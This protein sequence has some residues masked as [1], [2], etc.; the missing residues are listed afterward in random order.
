MINNHIG[1]CSCQEKVNC[2]SCLRAP[3][4]HRGG[5]KGI[6]RAAG[7]WDSPAPDT[8]TPFLLPPA[9]VACAHG[10]SASLVRDLLTHTAPL[11]AFSLP[12]NAATRAAVQC[13]LS[14]VRVALAEPFPEPAWHMQVHLQRGHYPAAWHLLVHCSLG[15]HPSV[16]HMK[17]QHQLV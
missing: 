10:L 9:F 16:H 13:A 2:T 17:M 15:L 3:T 5:R 11:L 14:T 7:L 4:G 8:P 1:S 6:H 12:N